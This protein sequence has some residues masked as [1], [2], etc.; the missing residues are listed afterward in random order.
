MFVINTMRF[1]NPAEGLAH[2][3]TQNI[4]VIRIKWIHE[5]KC[6]LPHLILCRRL[7]GREGN[8]GLKPPFPSQHPRASASNLG[9]VAFFLLALLIV[10]WIFRLWMMEGKAEGGGGR[11]SIKY[12]QWGAVIVGFMHK[13]SGFQK[14]GGPQHKQFLWDKEKK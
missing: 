6:A 4:F 9:L 11:E 14:V 7:K 1:Q 2:S 10:K 5:W 12:G 8:P 3:V 13:R